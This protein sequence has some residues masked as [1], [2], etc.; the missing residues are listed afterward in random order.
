MRRNEGGAEVWQWIELVDVE[1]VADTALSYAQSQVL[2]NG[3]PTMSAFVLT[4][5]SPCWEFD[6]MESGLID[7]GNQLKNM[8]IPRKSLLT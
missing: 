8:M 4:L 7:K 2:K 6:P 5:I 1:V 3:R